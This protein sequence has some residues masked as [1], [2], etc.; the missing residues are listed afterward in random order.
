MSTC[1]LCGLDGK[2]IALGVEPPTCFGCLPS[3][4]P[5]PQL[6]AGSSPMILS[7]AG[8]P[9]VAWILW[10]VKEAYPRSPAEPLLAGLAILL[11]L[12]FPVVVMV[13]R[14]ELFARSQPAWA[15]VA[16][17]AAGLAWCGPCLL[18]ALFAS[19]L[20]SQHGP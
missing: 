20:S 11:Y 2:R 12:S 15:W 7:V 17:S 5:T 6:A 18:G 10:L 13:L 3:A 14:Q 4:R 8:I 9:I 1:H 19:A 16:W